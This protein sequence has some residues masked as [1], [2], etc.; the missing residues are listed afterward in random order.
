M[1]IHEATITTVTE[2]LLCLCQT[3]PMRSGHLSYIP[4]CR[5]T[6]TVLTET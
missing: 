6:I 2:L 5:M 4:P 3:T 1:Q